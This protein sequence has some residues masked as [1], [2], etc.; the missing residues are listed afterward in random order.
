LFGCT[1]NGVSPD[2]FHDVSLEETAKG[3]T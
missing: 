3:E 1:F 2:Y